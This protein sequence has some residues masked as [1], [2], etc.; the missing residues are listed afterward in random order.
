M[1]SDAWA[2]PTLF[3]KYN[4][5]YCKLHAILSK[6]Q[7]LIKTAEQGLSCDWNISTVP[8]VI[9]THSGWQG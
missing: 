2:T 8:S 5:I 1:Y 4:R 3:L 6:P 7:T 9:M